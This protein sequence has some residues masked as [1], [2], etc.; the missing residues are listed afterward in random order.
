MQSR[1]LTTAG[2]GAAAA[3]VLTAGALPASAAA[4]ARKYVGKL[5]RTPFSNVQVT[6][7]VSHKK[8]RTLNVYANPQDQQSYQLEAYALPRLRTE[9]LKV[10]TYKIHTISGVTTTSDAFILSL[11]SAMGHAHLL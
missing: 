5:E 10:H 7:T 1:T 9:A 8:I 3:A 2:L 6:I 11:Y 4:S